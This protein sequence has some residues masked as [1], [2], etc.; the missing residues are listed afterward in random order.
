MAAALG[1]GPFD[2]F[3]YDRDRPAARLGHSGLL[4]LLNGNNLRDLDRHKAVIETRTG[5]LQT[6]RRKPMAV[7]EMA[8]P[9]ELI[10]A[11]P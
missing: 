10:D 8:L 1:W 11:D 5:A 9:W 7:G 4:W 6:Y 3:G 2:L